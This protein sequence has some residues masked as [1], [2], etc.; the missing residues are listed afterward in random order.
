[1]QAEMANAE[2]TLESADQRQAD[3]N[4][5]YAGYEATVDEEGC[6]DGDRTS[7]LMAQIVGPADAYDD[8][9]GAIRGI[10]FS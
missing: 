6:W 8:E 7:N 10:L 5:E 1:V 2:A 9:E 3:V 4:A